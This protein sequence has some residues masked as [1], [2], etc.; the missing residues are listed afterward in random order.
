MQKILE[1]LEE[2][3]KIISAIDHIVYVSY[4]IIN[5]EKILLKC[6]HYV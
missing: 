1:N 5:E 3:E 2:S 4:E 6:L